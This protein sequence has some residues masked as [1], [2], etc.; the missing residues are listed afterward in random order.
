MILQPTQPAALQPNPMHMVIICLP[1][2]TALLKKS[3]HIK[4][5]PRKIA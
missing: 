4:G 2:A 3:I 1:G 5:N